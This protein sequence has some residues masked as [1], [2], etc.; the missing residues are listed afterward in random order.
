MNA[1]RLQWKAFRTVWHSGY[2][3]EVRRSAL[4]FVLLFLIAFGSSLAFPSL[5]EA[6]MRRVSEMMNALGAGD[7]TGTLSALLLFSNNLQACALMML[8]G[9]VP[10]AQLSALPLGMNSM[11]L[12]VLLGQ[13]V[14]SGM[15][16]PLYF[17]SLLPHAVLELPALILSIG[18][19]LFVCG[20]LTRRC[21]HDES[22]L[23]L[24]EC[25]L[26]MSRLLLLTLPLLLA[27]AL[28]EA[29]ITP[30]AAALFQ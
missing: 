28:V 25:V 7:E 23:S 5:R 26:N 27:A 3:Q 14:A 30:M 17:A 4:A 2:K 15:S 9:L 20:Q 18:M 8:Y 6:A 11:L 16:V 19:G 13:Y 24:R 12:G 21:R 22:A 29:H 10:F 1:L